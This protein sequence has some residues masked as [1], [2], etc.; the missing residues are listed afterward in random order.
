MQISLLKPVL[1]RLGQLRRPWFIGL[2]L[3]AGIAGIAGWAIAQRQQSGADV[4]ALTVP[5]ASSDVALKVRGTGTIQ[6]IRTVNLSPKVAGRIKQIF[7]DQGDRVQQGQVLAKMDDTD[8]LAEVAQSRANLRLTQARLDTLRRPARSE[9]VDQ[10]QAGIDQAQAGVAQVESEK[11]RVQSDVTN[12]E[13]EVIRARGV[14]ADAQAKL[15]LAQS[16]LKSQQQLQAAG[17][18]SAISLEESLQQAESARQAVTQAKAQLAQNQIRVTQAIEQV[19]Q[20]SARVAQSEA[21]LGS[22]QAQRQQQNSLGSD[23]EIRQAVA[24]VAVAVAQVQ[25]TENRLA[26]TEV[27]APFEGTI[28][29]RYATVGAFVTPT[30]QASASG[31]GATSTSIFGLASGL[32]VLARV[33]EV[34]I[35]RITKNQAVEVKADAFPDQDFEGKVQRIAPEAVVEQSVTYFQVRAQI[36][37]GL[38]KLRSGMNVDLSFAGEQLNNATVVPTVAIVTKRGK[39]GVLVPG[40]DNKPEYKP[41]EIG[42]SI[43]DQTQVLKGVEPG[44]RIFKELPPGMKLDD[45]IKPEK[46]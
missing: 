30:T 13:S 3:L 15:T 26:E 11:L 45:I 44:D 4:S 34:D 29:Q 1:S 9:A 17:A 16:K 28:T 38:D 35:S 14:V 24:Q 8:L 5:V 43:K 22:A 37:N 6:P 42:A 2:V 10:S 32:E 40:K 12:A 7:V 18:V 41:I 23:G 27:R 20:V 33:P 39:P 36:T 21:Q 31:S 46:K 25:A 19:R